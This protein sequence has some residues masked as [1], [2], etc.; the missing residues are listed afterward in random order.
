MDI[1]IS[2]KGLRGSPS[3]YIIP[4]MPL[5]KRLRAHI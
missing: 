4:D 5:I 3:L 1:S 2:D